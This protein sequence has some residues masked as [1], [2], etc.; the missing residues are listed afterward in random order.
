[1]S[2]YT[3]TQS[4]EADLD[5]VLGFIAERD[6]HRRAL[7]VYEQFVEAFEQLASFPGMG[8]RKPQLTDDAI[9]WWPVFQ[10][11]VVYDAERTPIDILRVIHGARDLARL[12]SE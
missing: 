7:H 1:M 4:A 10:F 2:G 8:V 11:L 9:R 3:L 12:F 5:D 6:P